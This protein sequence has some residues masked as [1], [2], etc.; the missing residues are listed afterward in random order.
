MKITKLT[1]KGKVDYLY[2][3]NYWQED[4]WYGFKADISCRLGL[5]NSISSFSIYILTG[6]IFFREHSIWIVK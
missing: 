3:E 4:Y 1:N 2:I 6:S 5:D